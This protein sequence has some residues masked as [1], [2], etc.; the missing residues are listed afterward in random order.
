MNSNELRNVQKPGIS[1]VHF[2]GPL[3]LQN[4]CRLNWRTLLW[5]L[6]QPNHVHIASL[7]GSSSSQSCWVTVTIVSQTMTWLWSLV[8]VTVTAAPA[9]H[10]SSQVAGKHR[11]SLHMEHC[12]APT[13]IATSSNSSGWETTQKRWVH[14]L[15]NLKVLKVAVT[16]MTIAASTETWL[17]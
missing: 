11:G 3:S 15:H 17:L 5:P 9:T 10:N 6:L 4:I 7:P 1:C 13:V 14:I 2:F 12:D 8:A 16:A